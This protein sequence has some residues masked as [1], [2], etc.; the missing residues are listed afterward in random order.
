[1]MMSATP[2]LLI[3]YDLSTY[4]VLLFVKLVYGYF[5]I[6]LLRCVL[7]V[8]VVLTNGRYVP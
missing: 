3:R 2:Y 6:Y 7:K 5:N 1:M 4:C 8:S